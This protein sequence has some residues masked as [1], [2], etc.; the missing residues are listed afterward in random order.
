[1]KRVLLTG[2]AGFI[3]F[4]VTQRLL[5][6]G[7][8]V[9]GIDNLNRFYNEGLKPARLEILEKDPGFKFIHAD[10]ADL[11]AITEVLEKNSSLWWCIWRRRRA[12]ATPWKI[13][14]STC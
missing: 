12:Y 5:L 7:H 6:S 13:L 11:L 9:I 4:H 3:G 2:C 14:I 1:M 8:E 10:I